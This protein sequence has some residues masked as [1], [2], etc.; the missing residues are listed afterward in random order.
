MEDSRFK[1]RAWDVEF[2]EMVGP[3]YNGDHWIFECDS[4]GMS[5]LR[6]TG[7]EVCANYTTVKSIFM[8]YTGLKDK[9]GVDLY[10]GDVIEY[11]ETIGSSP[12]VCKVEFSNLVH[13]WILV[14]KGR[15]YYVPTMNQM[16]IVGNIYENSELIEIATD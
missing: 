1:F 7:D 4:D 2:G 6:E 12:I 11:E 5:L 8:Q 10:E 15:T 9:K 14:I 13:G 16:L 3:H